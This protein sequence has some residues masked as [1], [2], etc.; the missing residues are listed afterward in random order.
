MSDNFFYRLREYYLKVAEV[1]RGEADAASIFPNSSDIGISREK[2]YVD[3]LKQHAPS[4]CNVFLGGFLFDDDGMESRQLDVIVTTDTAPRFNFHNK[5]GDGKS[6]SPVEGT[7]GV[8]SIKSMLDKTQLENAL[9]GIASIP[10]TKSLNGRISITITISNYDDWPYKVIYATNGL[11][12]ITIINH[13]NSFYC[14][15]PEIPLNRRPNII[16]V[17]GKYIIMRV[18]EGVNVYNS[19]TKKKIELSVGTYHLIKRYAD[20]QGIIW[21]LDALQINATAST[22]ILYSY[23]DFINKVNFLP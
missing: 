22:Q 13:I 17:A 4:K 21:V 18:I 23:G 12:G 2:V 7:L 6:F 8:V 20:L 16:H 1:L 11:E 10:P 9:L 5:D 14:C 19:S 3:F 15:H